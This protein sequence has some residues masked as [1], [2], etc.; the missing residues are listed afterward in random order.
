MNNIIKRCPGCGQDFTVDDIFS[1]KNIIPIGITFVGKNMESAYYF[2]QHEIPECGSSFIIKTGKLR[3]LIKEKIPEDKLKS[4][5]QCN[6]YCND[7]SD[8]SN[9]KNNCHYAPYRRLLFDILENKDLKRDILP[10][11]THM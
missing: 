7:I 8:L 3:H 2:F 1:D 6:T 10:V 5:S 11:I 4:T 9:C